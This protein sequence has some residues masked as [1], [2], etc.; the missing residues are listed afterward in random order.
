MLCV[1]TNNNATASFKQTSS[2]DYRKGYCV[3]T[4]DNVVGGAYQIRPSTYLPG[5]ESDFFLEISASH[6]YTLSQVQ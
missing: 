5:Q 3:L 6:D 1:S 4:L 2:G